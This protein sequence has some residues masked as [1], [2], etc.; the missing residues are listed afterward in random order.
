[1]IDEVKKI[2]LEELSKQKAEYHDKELSIIKKL[3]DLRIKLD[4]LQMEQSRGITVR[5]DF[6]FFEKWITRRDEYKRFKA[7]SKRFSEL[8]KLIREAEAN[9]AEEQ[10][11]VNEELEKTGIHTALQE[12][13]QK[14]A[15]IKNAKTIYAMGITPTD[16][17]K[18]LESNGILPILSE[19]DKVIF[20]HPR[21]YSSKSALI[22]VHKT[23]YAPTANMIR[24]SKDSNVE[25][26]RNITINGVGYEYSFKSARDTVHMAMNDEVSSHMYGSWDDCKYAILIP[27]EDIPNRKIGRA[28]PMDTFT[29][30]SIELSENTWILCPKNEVDRLKAFNPKVHVLGYEGENVQGFSQPFLTQLGYRAEDVGMWNWSDNESAQQFY[31]LMVKE[32]IKKGIHSDTYFNEDEDMLNAINQAVSLSKLLRDNHLITNP[33]D[34]EKIMK[35]LKDN[36]QDFGFILSGLGDGSVTEHGYDDLEPQS[37]KGNHKQVDIFLEEMKKNGFNISNVYQDIMRKLCKETIC[38]GNK[39]NLDMVSS[40]PEEVSEEERGII[41]ELQAGLIY[42]D[43]M[44]GTDKRVEAFGKF[45]S[46]AICNAILHS[47]E[48]EFSNVKMQ[49]EQPI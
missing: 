2:K 9:L 17:I 4:S 10:S 19:S 39:N 15:L 3:I 8:P 41:E 11:R 46:I 32:N 5:G 37:I 24:S 22:G 14:M 38:H 6:S 13:E 12:I 45:L 25:Y 36:Y 47:K 31:E 44:S 33:Q 26:K 27:F 48:I 42:Y 21:D 49:E 7:Q 23:R 18:F 20:S 30:G 34:I 40:L 43:L 16:A 35:Q 28:T 29:R 1:M